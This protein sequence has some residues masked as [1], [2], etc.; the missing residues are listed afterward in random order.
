MR[1]RVASYLKAKGVQLADLVGHEIAGIPRK[2]AVRK[3][4]ARKPNSRRTGAT[5][6]RSVSTAVVEGNANARSSVIK[7]GLATLKPRILSSSA[8]ASG[9]GRL[10]AQD[11]AHVSRLRLTRFRPGSS[12]S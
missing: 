1:H 12:S 6:I 5:A 2:P 11:I 3:K 10:R 9:F 7:Q 8:T 4:L